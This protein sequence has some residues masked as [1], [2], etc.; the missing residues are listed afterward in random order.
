MKMWTKWSLAT[1]I[2]LVGFG[3]QLGAAHAQSPINGAFE[4]K[5][6]PYLPA[7]DEE[8]GG[9]GPYEAFFENK[10][11][12]L[13][14]LEVDY[15][16]WQG[17]GKLSVGGHIGYGRVRGRMLID[18][19]EAVDSGDRATFRIIPLRG[20]LIYRYDYSALNHGIPLVPVVKAGLD[21]YLWRISE[22]DGNTAVADGTPA[23]GGKAGW[24]V[25]AGLHLHL[26]F[27]DRR[28]AAAFDLTWGINNSY[29]FAEY[30]LSRINNFGGAGLDLS[31][32]HW[33]FGL[34]FEF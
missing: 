24:H 33:A 10:S 19:D 29:L 34:A 32:N 9:A 13:G 16:L 12:L 17:F 25:S 20:S 21:Y 8:F 23:I 2:V 26:N 3:V 31:A 5:L 11:M 28:S 1:L 27:I 7:V 6:G 14:E 30:T 15:H 22:P 4:F 18:D